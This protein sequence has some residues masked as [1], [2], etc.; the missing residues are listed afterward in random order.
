MLKIE[1]M[2]VYYNH[3]HAVQDV[4]LNVKK[5]EIVSIIGANGAGKSSLVKAIM[6]LV[7]FNASLFKLDDI[8]LLKGNADKLVSLGM[9]L[10]PEGRQVFPDLSVEDNLEMGAYTV[11][12][13]ELIKEKIKEMFVLFPRLEERRKQK[14]G[15]LSGGEQQLLAMARALMSSPKLLLLDEP[16]MGLAPIMVQEVFK[17]IK[18]INENGT[19]ILLI[20]Q[21]ASMA[22]NIADYG[23]VLESGRLVKEGKAQELLNDYDLKKSYLG[24]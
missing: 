13:H 17:I 10:V 12:S 6:H 23:Y 4:N 9:A 5:G 2:N 20:E 16:S 8:D 7:K 14:A 18:K 22:L 3:I 19:T 15:T 1:K 24:G 11:K 21:N